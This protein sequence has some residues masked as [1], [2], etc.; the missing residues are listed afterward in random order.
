[1]TFEL[2]SQS[3]KLNKQ[4]GGRGGGGPNESREPGIFFLNK[5][6]SGG[7]FIRDPRVALFECTCV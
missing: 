2:L 4:G 7:T 5:K 1:M 3:R 6:K